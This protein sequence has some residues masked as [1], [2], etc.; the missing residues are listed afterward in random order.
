MR[1]LLLLRVEGRAR[2]AAQQRGEQGSAE[3]VQEL[4]TD[5]EEERGGLAELRQLAAAVQ[6]WARPEGGQ[7]EQ[8]VGQRDAQDHY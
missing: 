4:E 5:R 7:H 8:N 6:H 2:P 3:H 1:A